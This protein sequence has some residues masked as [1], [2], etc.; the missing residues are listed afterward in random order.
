[1]AALNEI[2]KL[3]I[4]LS[5]KPTEGNTSKGNLTLFNIQLPV[6]GEFLVSRAKGI[7]SLTYF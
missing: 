5:E 4:S 3:K 7:G 1:M 2:Q 6:K